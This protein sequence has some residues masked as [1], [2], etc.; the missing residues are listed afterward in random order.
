M[1]GTTAIKTRSRLSALIGGFLIFTLALV[2]TATGQ[3]AGQVLRVSV[4][5]NTLKNSTKLSEEKKAEVDRLGKMAS[6]AS[7][8]GKHGEALKHYFHAMAIMRGNERTAARALSSALTIKASRVVL[9]PLQSIQI[10]LGQLFA[11]DD[12][13][14]PTATLRI[15]LQ[16]R[17]GDELRALKTIEVEPNFFQKPWSTE[18]TIPSVETGRYRL[19]LTLTPT[20]AGADPVT[21]T[22]NVYV[23]KGLLSRVQAIKSRAARIEERLKTK[24]DDRLIAV[25]PSVQYRINLADLANA[26]E[27]GPDRIEFGE[28]LTEAG[29]LL[30]ALDAG[31]DPFAVR[32]GDLKKAY[33]SKVDDT[34]QPYRVFVPSTYDGSK[35]YPLVVA[36]HGMGGDENSYFD[37][38]AQGAFK[39]EAERRGYI[40]ACP[41]GRQPASMYVGAAETDVVDVIKEVQR[42]YRIDA[43]RI[44]MTGHSMGGF[45]TWSVAMNHPD[46]FAGLAPVA[47][48]GNPA[49]MSRIAH[50]PQLVVHG[51]DDKTVPVERSRVMVAAAKALSTELKYIEIPSGDHITVAARTFKDVFD[52]FDTHKRRRAAEKAAGASSR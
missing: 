43:D 46:L 4:G 38:Y 29:G 50:I 1:N 48:G 20:P 19:S 16:S 3:D 18:V 42:S 35:P 31:R 36:L 40:V 37:L 22:T 27:I 9:E 47:G 6:A 11:L 33:R 34:L 8:A 12:K 21:K 28:E 15:S 10:K 14:S 32:R 7:A 23:E 30:D 45:G 44:Y 24:R 26:G 41:K 2:A 51:D 13:V 25:L 39:V 5:Y 17:T 49:N 52:W